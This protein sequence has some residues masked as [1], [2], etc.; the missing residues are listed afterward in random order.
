MFTVELICCHSR[1]IFPL[2]RC[3]PPPGERISALLMVEH[4]R[5][6]FVDLYLVRCITAVALSVAVL[7]NAK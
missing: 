2:L 1:N 4:I 3:L 5:F 7:F 6:I